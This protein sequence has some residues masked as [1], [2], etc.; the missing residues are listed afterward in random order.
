MEFHATEQTV[1]NWSGDCLVIGLTEASLPISGEFAELNTQVSGLLQELIDEAEF[2]GKA[3]S[4]AV[5]RVDSGSSIRKLG[6]VGLGSADT[7]TAETLRLACRRRRSTGQS[8]EM[9]YPG[10]EP[11][12][13]GRKSSPLCPGHGRRRIPGPARRQTFQIRRR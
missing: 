10:A 4:K 1:L 11:T 8:R 9:L 12:D 5:I 3:Q 13:A 2:T 6:I 7:I